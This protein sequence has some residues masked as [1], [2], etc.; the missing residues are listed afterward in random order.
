MRGKNVS[1]IGEKARTIFLAVIMI[2]SVMAA[3]VAFTGST[4]ADAPPDSPATD[5][6]NLQVSLLNESNDAKVTFGV[7]TTS[8]TINKTNATDSDVAVGSVNSDLD[9]TAKAIQFAIDNATTEYSTVRV[10]S[11]IYNSSSDI[12]ID[13]D[14]LTLEGPNAGTPANESRK[15]EATINRTVKIDNA[16]GVTVDG[17]KIAEGS[18]QLTSGVSIQPGSSGADGITVTNSIIENMSAAGGGGTSDFTFGVL[19]FG[20]NLSD[21]TITD[22]TPEPDRNNG[23]YRCDCRTQHHQECQ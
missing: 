23:W 15:N 11:G 7:N 10:G 17:F 21:V 9:N 6:G 14:G 16:S 1:D 18:R 20:G 12:L 5:P 13:S 4:A 19:S 22:L 8:K 2:T 3:G